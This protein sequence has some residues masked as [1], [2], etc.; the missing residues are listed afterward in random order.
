MVEGFDTPGT[1][2]DAEMEG[3]RARIAGDC[4]RLPLAEPVLDE[5]AAP[6]GGRGPGR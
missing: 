3:L 5:A 1:V 2:S 4:P 6:G